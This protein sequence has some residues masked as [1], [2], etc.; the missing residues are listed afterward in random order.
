M[1]NDDAGHYLDLNLTPKLLRR[2]DV[3]RRLGIGR[4]LLQTLAADKDSGFPQPVRVS[5]GRIA[6]RTAE[7]DEWADSLPHVAKGDFR[8]KALD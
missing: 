2:D 4:S 6:W 7:V 3:C 5:R 1:S 8:T